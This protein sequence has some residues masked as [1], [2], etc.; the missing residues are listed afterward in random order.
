MRLVLTHIGICPTTV[1]WIGGFLSSIYFLVPINCYASSFL[2]PIRHLKWGQ[3]LSPLLFLVVD[4]RLSRAL[5]SYQS[6]GIIKCIKFG[7]S[8]SPSHFS[9]MDD[10][11]FFG[12]GSPREVKYKDI[13][14]L[15]CRTCMK[16]YSL[17]SSISFNG[18]T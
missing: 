3:P 14:D 1:C 2:K 5:N 11:F 8:L 17:K 13:L 4:K 18:I 9:I 12:I 7:R 16:L 10:V 6:N 15:Y